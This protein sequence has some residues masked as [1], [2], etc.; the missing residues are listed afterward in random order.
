MIRADAQVSVS[1]FAGLVGVPRR[2]YCWRLAKLRRG[3]P[4]KGPRPAP[5]VDRIEPAA[6]ELAQQYP[7][8]GHRKIWAMGFYEGWDLGSQSSG[9]R[10]MARRGLLQPVRYQAQRRQLAAARRAVFVDPPTRRNRVWQADF[11]EFETAAQGTWQLGGVVDYVSKLVLACPVTATQTA[12]D[13]LAARPT[14]PT[15]GPGTDPRTPTA[16]SSAGS[17]PSNTSASTARTSPTESTSPNTSPPSPTHTTRSDPT[18]HSA[19]SGP[20]TPTC[21]TRPSN[22]TRPKLSKEL[23]TDNNTKAVKCG[24]Q[25]L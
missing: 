9:R 5:V 1:K 6:A 14:S 24:A 25:S 21:P 13:P 19:G 22:R 7:A 12:T 16:S 10:A 4:A 11:S 15:C 23:D 8:W 17:R 2:T 3:D 20:S 18:K